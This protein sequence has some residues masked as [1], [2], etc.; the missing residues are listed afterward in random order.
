MYSMFSFTIQYYEGV[1]LLISWSYFH[2]ALPFDSLV[3]HDIRFPC[4]VP[5]YSEPQITYVNQGFAV[6]VLTCS[7]EGYRELLLEYPM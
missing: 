1:F 4:L 3:I 7:M 2:N 5:S 6:Y